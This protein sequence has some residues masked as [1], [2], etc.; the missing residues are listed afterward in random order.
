VGALH[1]RQCPFG[2]SNH[3][4]PNGPPITMSPEQF[5]AEFDARTLAYLPGFVHDSRPLVIV[6][7]AGAHT[8][9]GHTLLVSLSNQA[10]RIHKR[11]VFVGDLQQPLLCTDV[12]RAGT[13]VS[14]TLELARRINP[15]I[16]VEVVSRLPSSERLLTIGVG[17]DVTV[18]LAL[19][20]VGWVAQLGSHA[21][22]GTDRTSIWGALLASCLGANVALHRLLGHHQLPAADFSLWQHGRESPIQGPAEDGPVDAGRV[23]QAGAGAVGAALDFFLSFFGVR[24]LWVVVDGDSVDASNLNRQLI[25]LAEDAGFP[26]G[27]PA[28]KAEITAERM[29][30]TFLGS[31]HW[32]GADRVDSMA[33]TTS[34]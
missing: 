20:A 21:V 24:G 25:F 16:N 27:Q 4:E 5:A 33:P 12:F 32:W 28:N 26:S 31:P 8:P 11:I 18:D 1:A 30:G 2:T 17:A 13:L 3:V 9:A 7:G 34:S 14:A 22:V 6:V 19:G 23:L 15:L 10:A 29:G